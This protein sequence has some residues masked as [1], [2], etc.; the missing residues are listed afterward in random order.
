MKQ[1]LAIR[2]LNMA[3]ALRRPEAGCIHHTDRG[4]QYGAHDYQKILH[5]HGLKSSISGK[6]NCH[7]NSTVE[8]FFKS[9][10]AELVWRRD[11]QTRRELEIALLYINGL[12]QPAPQTFSLGLEITR[13][14]RTEGCLT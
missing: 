3:V 12:S 5:R 4:L 10:K 9:L 2:A 8:S 11:W 6:G 7:D 1:V 13:S 14:L